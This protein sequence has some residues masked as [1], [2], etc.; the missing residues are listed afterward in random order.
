[1]KIKASTC[2]YMDGYAY[3]CVNRLCRS[4]LNI[5]N[6]T[7]FNTSQYTIMELSRICFHYFVRGYNATQTHL[8]LREMINNKL[9]AN[10]DY[11]ARIDH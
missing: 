2:R 9:N 7:F 8:E 5:R 11:G 1:M 10:G 4:R 3:F 6:G